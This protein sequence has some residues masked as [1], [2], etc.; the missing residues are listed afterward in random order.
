MIGLDTYFNVAQNF[1]AMPPIS[2]EKT[3]GE[4][5]AGA[6]QTFSIEAMMRDGR[7]LQAGTSHYLGTNFAQV[8][9]IQY[10]NANGELTLCHTTSWGMSTRMIGGIVMTHGDDKGLVLPPRLAPY[11]VVIVPLGKAE[12]LET[13]TAAAQDVAAQLRA[14]GVRVH[15]D[16]RVNLTPGFKYNDW[17]LKGVPVRLEIGGRDLEAGVATVALRISEDGKQAVPLAELSTRSPVV[18]EEFQQFLLER[19]TRFRDENTAVV[20]DWD[21][22]VTA[23]STGWASVLHCGRPECEDEIKEITKATPRNIP[24]GAP[25]ETGTCVRCGQPSAYGQRIFFGRAY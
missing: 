8:F 16:T 12:L 6:T 21:A 10:T 4:R 25:A 17:E 9:G 7:A 14:V 3:A 2:G 20:D 1:A 22:F 5:F 23:V 24:L 15:I 11:Q 13:T 19:A 18:L